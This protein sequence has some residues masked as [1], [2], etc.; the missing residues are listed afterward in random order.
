[1]K[2][3]LF[4]SVQTQR[5]S[6][7]VDGTQYFKDLVDSSVEAE[8]LGRHSTFVVE[9]QLRRVLTSTCKS[10]SCGYGADG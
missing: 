6:V 3:G 5:G 10:Q 2:F 8:G 9:H 4:G 7:D 1:M